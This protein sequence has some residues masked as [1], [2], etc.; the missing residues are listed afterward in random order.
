MK[1]IK[2][3]ILI[4]SL[5]APAHALCEEQT[6]SQ[7]ISNFVKTHYAELLAGTVV[8]LVVPTAVVIGIVVFIKNKKRY[9]Y[10]PYR[11]L[12]TSKTTLFEESS[13]PP[14]IYAIPA[15]EVEPY[16]DAPKKGPAQANQ[17]SNDEYFIKYFEQRDTTEDAFLDALYN[18]RVVYDQDIDEV[19]NA[20]DIVAKRKPKDWLLKPNMQ[21]IADLA[22]TRKQQLPKKLAA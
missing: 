6:S 9:R 3:S 22:L 18:S 19:Y 15:S 20:F 13:N 4:Y 11:V 14:V 10:N 8:S 2:Y 7:K 12:V 1:T 17:L 5:I 21:A 16:T